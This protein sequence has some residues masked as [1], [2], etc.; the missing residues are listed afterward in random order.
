MRYPHILPESSPCNRALPLQLADNT[1]ALIF[2]P[3][4]KWLRRIPGVKE[5]TVRRASSPMTC[6]AQ[7]LQGQRVLRLPLVAPHPVATGKPHEALRPYQEDDRAPPPSGAQC[8]T[9]P[10]R[11]HPPAA[12]RVDTPR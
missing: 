8:V 5:H 11:S 1:P 9:S 2:E 6:V 12:P 7:A 4:Q 3:L 10:T